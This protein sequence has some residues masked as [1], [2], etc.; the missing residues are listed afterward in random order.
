MGKKRQYLSAKFPSYAAG[1]AKT[2]NTG[3][4]KYMFT[5][6]DQEA[7][8]ILDTLERKGRINFGKFYSVKG[9]ALLHLVSDTKT[10]EFLTVDEVENLIHQ[11]IDA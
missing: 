3:G 5:T 1:F 11:E 4:K 10:E 2:I 7:E 8:R 6:Q 9:P